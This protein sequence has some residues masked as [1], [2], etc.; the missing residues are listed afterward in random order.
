M[1]RAFLCHH[2][3]ASTFVREVVKFV[4]RGLD[5][6]LTQEH[7]PKHLPA[8]A[9]RHPQ[10]IAAWLQMLHRWESALNSSDVVLHRNAHAAVIERLERVDYRGCE[11]IRD[12]RDMLVSCYYSHRYSHP[13]RHAYQAEHRQSLESL[14]MEQGLLLELD[15][16]SV[17]LEQLREC[18][19]WSDRLL[20]LRFED[21]IESPRPVLHQAFAFLR[22]DCQEL[23]EQALDRYGFEAQS[24]GRPRGQV[25]VHH[26]YR[27]GVAGDWRD[28]F[29]SQ[30]KG[31]FKRRFG[32]LLL[33]LGYENDS[34]W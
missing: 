14:P 16:S 12:P 31:E 33:E 6:D 17:Y 34:D 3:C 4:A 10:S 25:D 21:L 19:G 8:R 11:F 26:H 22:L 29:N 18:G 7:R 23:L 2:R 24:Q 30:I 13:V 32:D 9:H 28:H 15:Y 27:R 1:V 20:R 5:L